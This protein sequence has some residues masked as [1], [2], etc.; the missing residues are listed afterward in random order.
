M[1]DYGYLKCSYSDPGK[2]YIESWKILDVDETGFTIGVKQFTK[3]FYK[4]DSHSTEGLEEK[5]IEHEKTWYDE[6]RPTLGYPKWLEHEKY[7]VVDEEKA[8]LYSK[9]RINLPLDYVKEHT[10]DNA[11]YGLLVKPYWAKSA[12][13]VDKEL[14]E[15]L[16]E[17]V[18]NIGWRPDFLSKV[19]HTWSLD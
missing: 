10:S 11:P 4:G 9:E 1:T 17:W 18:T 12:T 15:I 3:Y 14:L 19:T 5:I 6:N 8:V 16:G 2:D 13:E 7:F